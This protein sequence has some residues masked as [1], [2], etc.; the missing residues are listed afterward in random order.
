MAQTLTKARNML[1]PFI[2]VK[3]SMLKD[4]NVVNPPKTAHCSKTTSNEHI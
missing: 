1:P 2:K 3:V 4:E